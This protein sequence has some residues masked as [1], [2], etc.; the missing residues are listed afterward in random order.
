[1][2]G[3]HFK[4]DV[5]DQSRHHL[6]EKRSFFKLTRLNFIMDLEFQVRE[7]IE[8]YTKSDRF[9]IPKE[10]IVYDIYEEP[11]AINDEELIQVVQIHLYD[12]T[13]RKF[14]SEF[15]VD[16][17]DPEAVDIMIRGCFQ[18]IREALWEELVYSQIDNG[19]MN[20]WAGV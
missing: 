10:A 18:R 3:K 11:D 13:G 6:I 20:D 14:G 1:M 7:S 4:I 15:A 12:D 5:A 17:P 2:N 16:D 9:W 8:H 19:G